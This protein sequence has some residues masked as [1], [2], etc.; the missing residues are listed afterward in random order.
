M[1]TINWGNICQ[2]SPLRCS[3]C[4]KTVKR[5]KALWRASVR[6]PNKATCQIIVKPLPAAEYN[7]AA[8]FI[9]PKAITPGCSEWLCWN[10]VKITD[11]HGMTGLDC[12]VPANC[13]PA[14]V[15]LEACG[16]A[17]A[18]PWR[19]HGRLSQLPDFLPQP[20]SL[21]TICLWL[22][23]W[24][25]EITNSSGNGWLGTAA[26]QRSGQAAITGPVFLAQ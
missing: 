18:V 3:L 10:K 22:S 17:L 24:A 26:W 15:T 6:K 21:K 7:Q 25:W 1:T 8:Q 2:K 13:H 4:R 20:F 5:L 12:A 14:G 16:P 19:C 9:I 23:D 11:K